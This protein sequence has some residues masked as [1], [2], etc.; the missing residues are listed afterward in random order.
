LLAGKL[1][2]LAEGFAKIAAASARRISENPLS[3]V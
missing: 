2:W 1:E 3:R